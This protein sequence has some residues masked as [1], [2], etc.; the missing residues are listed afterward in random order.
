M[1]LQNYELPV[2]SLY[3]CI[4]EVR[5]SASHQKVLKNFLQLNGNIVL[6]ELFHSKHGG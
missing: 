6:A 5:N 1:G 2:Y 3:L 4:Q